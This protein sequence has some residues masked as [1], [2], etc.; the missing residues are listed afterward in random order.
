MCEV[1]GGLD[2][3][4]AMAALEESGYD[5]YVTLHQAAT[6]PTSPEDFVRRTADYL[7]G[8]GSAILT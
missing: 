2:F 4:P 7:K 5:G 1:D 6:P 3:A 8:E